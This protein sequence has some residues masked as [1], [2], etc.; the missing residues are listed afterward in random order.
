[1]STIY[2][3][4]DSAY[5]P[6][7][8]DPCDSH[9]TLGRYSSQEKA[10]YPVVPYNTQTFKYMPVS[11]HFDI[12]RL[13]QTPVLDLIYSRPFAS[14][15]YGVVPLAETISPLLRK[16]GTMQDRATGESLGTCTLIAENLVMVARHAIQGRNVGNIQ[17]RLSKSIQYCWIC[18]F[19]MCD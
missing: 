14:K 10:F 15:Q 16:M 9:A 2:A 19:Q 12:T 1:M 5:P 6:R 18:K 7:K 3:R 8:P 13:R 11:G 17:V 4:Y